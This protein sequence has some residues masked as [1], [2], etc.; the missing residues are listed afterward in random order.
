MQLLVHLDFVVFDIQSSGVLVGW[1]IDGRVNVLKQ[2]VIRRSKCL[3]NHKHLSLPYHWNV[4]SVLFE[5][6]LGGGKDLLLVSAVLS[7]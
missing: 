2:W 6:L 5:I 4:Y 3:L 1:D 7:C